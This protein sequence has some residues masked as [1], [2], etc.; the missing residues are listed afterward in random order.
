ML[1][2]QNSS[3][4]FKVRTDGTNLIKDYMSDVF[5]SSDK[6]ESLLG[7]SKYNE[8]DFSINDK[9]SED[10]EINVNTYKDSD[11]SLNKVKS[12]QP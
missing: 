7:N 8:D 10:I 2:S 6:K 3:G 12:E 1:N 9:Q 11:P 4:G 5:E